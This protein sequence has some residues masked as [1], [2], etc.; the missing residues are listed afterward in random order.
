MRGSYE[1][2]T[3]DLHAGEVLGLAGVQGSGR[4][5]LCRTLFGAEGPDSGRMLLDGV[6]VRFGSPADAVE[7]GI[8]YVPAERRTEGIVAG[9]SVRR[10][11]TLSHIEE[12]QKGPFL[13]QRR[14]LSLVRHWI[15]RLHI[16]TP[17][18][19]TP[20]GNLSGGNQQKVVL[21]KWLISQQPKVLVLDHP[22]RG[23]DVGAKAEV[24]ALIRGL[25]ASGIAIVLIGD[26]LD[27]I[28]ALSHN[29][30]VMR[31]GKISGTFPAPPGN[32]PTP[33]AIIERM[34]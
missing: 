1:A 8:S 7:V 12:V 33:L 13:D 2:V 9:L 29:I 23:L 16:K 25:A 21:A 34:V 20:A 22:M 32:K 30:I 11:I 26:T 18:P 14:E 31:D 15:D 27:E 17:S 6:E 5:T 28:I 4:E 3:F 10:N 24:F 19:E